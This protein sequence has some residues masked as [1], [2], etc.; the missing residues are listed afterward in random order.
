MGNYSSQ[1]GRIAR[2]LT[3]FITRSSDIMQASPVGSRLL[4]TFWQ[5]AASAQLCGV[6]TTSSTAFPPRTDESLDVP[7]GHSQ[8]DMRSSVSNISLNRRRDLSLRTDVKFYNQNDE[9]FNTRELLRVRIHR[10]HQQ[11]TWYWL[12]ANSGR[13]RALCSSTLSLSV[14]WTFAKASVSLW[15]G[16]TSLLFGL[17]DLGRVCTDEHAPSYMKQVQPLM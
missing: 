4:Q 17:P 8:S 16:G 1:L 15:Q 9:P 10:A 13:Q 2:A 3:R 11:S 7:A 12:I 14:Q 5:R 6:S